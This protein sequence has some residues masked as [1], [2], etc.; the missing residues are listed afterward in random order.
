VWWGIWLVAAWP[1]VGL[2]TIV[3]PLAMTATLVLGTGARLLERTMMK[4]PGYPAYAARTS[5]F[6]PLPPKRT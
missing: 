6:F 3:S 5:M 1:W 2:L 4:R